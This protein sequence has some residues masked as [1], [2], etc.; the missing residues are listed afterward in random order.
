MAPNETLASL[1]SLT[2]AV[3]GANSL[4]GRL[5]L[6][7]SKEAGAET[8]ALVR[9]P[10][11]LPAARVIQ[12]WMG[13]PAAEEALRSADV[14]AH[15]TGELF[16]TR[17]EYEAAN[18]ATARRVAD[19]VRQGRARR[20]VSV[21]YPGADPASRNDFLRTKGEAEGLLAATGRESV[22]L[23]VHAIIN[24]PDDPGPFEEALIAQ[25]GKAVQTLGSGRQQIWPVH[26]RDVA[27]AVAAALVRGRP[28]VYDLSGPDLMTLDGLIQ[29]LNRDPD[30]R[31]RHTPGPLARL[32]SRFVADLSPTFV[33]LM[34]TARPGEPPA[35]VVAE[36]GLVQTSLRRL[37]GGAPVT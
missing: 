34:L 29:L 8:W 22:V 27:E 24:S 4:V 18:V 2:V 23:R 37:W 7:L 14:V 31:I 19:A 36:F 35:R 5:L 17:A 11:D 32:A 20:V 25:P 26:R 12:D 3:T 9:K 10:A 1:S 28:G 33:D 16:G 6:P 30:V 13:A 21:S 15:L